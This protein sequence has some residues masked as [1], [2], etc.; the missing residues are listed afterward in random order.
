MARLRAPL[1]AGDANDETRAAGAW[2]ELAA[3]VGE[4]NLPALF[5]AWEQTEV[6]PADPSP[7]L[8]AAIKQVSANPQIDG[9]WKTAAPLLT[10]A[11][12]MSKFVPGRAAAAAAAAAAP[13]T[14]PGDMSKST[15]LANDDGKSAG[16]RSIAGTGHA[17][18]FEAPADG[19]QLVAVK[20]FGSRYGTQ[21]P[22]A[23]DFHVYLCD[24]DGAQIK[25]FP[26]PYKSFLR[27]GDRWVTLKLPAPTEVPKN[28]ILCVAFNPTQ[29]KG[30]YV[31]F[32]KSADGDSR[33]GLPGDLNDAFGQ[34]D[35]MIRAVVV[36]GK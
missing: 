21:Q 32:D 26:F 24:A 2:M 1:T 4:K 15:E 34:G 5:A 35:W 14:K 3:L 18:T 22:P 20:I 33:T 16:K 31:H 23:E 25:D 10:A 7:A 19:F 9:W 12:P 27:G 17:V 29:T 8:L 30:V 28:F 6:D 36:A 13:A 11:R